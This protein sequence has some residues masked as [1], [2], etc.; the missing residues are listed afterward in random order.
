MQLVLQ[1]LGDVSILPSWC[2]R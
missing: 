2:W 1:W